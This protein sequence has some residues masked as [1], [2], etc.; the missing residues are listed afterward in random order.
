LSFRTQV[1]IKLSITAPTHFIDNIFTIMLTAY[2]RG[3]RTSLKKAMTSVVKRK[4]KL[5]NLHLLQLTLLIIDL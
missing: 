1:F 5:E 4:W 3:Y 2:G